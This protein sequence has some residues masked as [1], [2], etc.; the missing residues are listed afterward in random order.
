MAAESLT[1]T[2]PNWRRVARRML[3]APGISLVAPGWPDA[4]RRI[5]QQPA[6]RA[7]LRRAATDLPRVR[8]AVNAGA[9]EGLHSALIRRY[10]ASARLLEFDL[11]RPRALGLDPASHR[12]RGSLTAIPLQ[13][14]SADLVVCTEVLEHVAD[15]ER[16]VAEIRRVLSS[17]GALV[18]SVPTPPAVFD[19]AHVREG[20]TLSQLGAL[21]ARHGL[22]I[23]DMQYCMYGLF[24][25]VLRF[26]RPFRVPHGVIVSIA[27]CDRILRL[28]SP[29]DLVVL[30]RVVQ[31]P[32]P[33]R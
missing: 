31:Q 28:G 21:F 23:T 5:V 30:A 13:T 2:S 9:G 20:Y 32:Q 33:G 17:A 7:M 25:C 24:K 18:L 1:G 16:A 15:D 8:T 11:S 26:W 29:M 3:A 14:G 19:P 4:G 22:A 6:L 27:W 12:F 10:I